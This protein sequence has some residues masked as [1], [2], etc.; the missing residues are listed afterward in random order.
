MNLRHGNSYASLDATVVTPTGLSPNLRRLPHL[1]CHECLS[2]HVCSGA[3]DEAGNWVE[4][5]LSIGR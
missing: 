4:T 1:I 5:E 2:H 3:P